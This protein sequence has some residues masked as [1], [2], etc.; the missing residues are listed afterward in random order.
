MFMV[1]RGWE[2]LCAGRGLQGLNFPLAPKEGTSWLS[3]QL[4]QMWS[5]KGKKKRCGLKGVSSQTSKNG[6]RHYYAI[7]TWGFNLGHQ[8]EEEI[9]LYDGG[10]LNML[11]TQATHTGVSWYSFTQL[12]RNGNVQ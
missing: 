9:L 5:K 12:K 7:C 11:V 10:K 3:Y 6:V 1:I 4:S 8:K 2:F